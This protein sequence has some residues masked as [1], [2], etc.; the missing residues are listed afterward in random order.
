[1]KDIRLNF[2][3]QL[4]SVGKYLKE[5]VLNINIDSDYYFKYLLIPNNNS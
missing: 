2:K 1:M 3:K 4:K 5:W